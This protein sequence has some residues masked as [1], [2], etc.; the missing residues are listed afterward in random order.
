PGFTDEEWDAYRDALVEAVFVPLSVAAQELGPKPFGHP[1]KNSRTDFRNLRCINDPS[2]GDPPGQGRCEVIPRAKRRAF[3]PGGVHLVWFDN[4]WTDH[5]DAGG[6]LT[7]HAISIALWVALH[8]PGMSGLEDPD[9]L[10]TAAD[11]LCTPPAS[12]Q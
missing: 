6:N 3:E 7:D 5:I 11:K 2:R 10:F 4:P 9:S 12:W 1:E 8:D